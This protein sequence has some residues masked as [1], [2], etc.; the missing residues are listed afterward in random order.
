MVAFSVYALTVEYACNTIHSL[1]AVGS[2][3]KK[4][5]TIKKLRL[6]FLSLLGKEANKLRLSQAQAKKLVKNPRLRRLPYDSVS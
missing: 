5:R 1:P 3:Q 6:N 4:S 2:G